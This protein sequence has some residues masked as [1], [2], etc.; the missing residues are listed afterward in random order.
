MSDFHPQ[1]IE[2]VAGAWDGK[3]KGNFTH[4]PEPKP[5]ET[6]LLFRYAVAQRERVLELDSFFGEFLEAACAI[7][8]VDQL[9]EVCGKALE[10]R[11]A[12][13]PEKARP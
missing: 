4:I 10:I 7:L 6:H 1:A 13:A 2:D 9:N 3:I 11:A 12:S 8:S 5:G